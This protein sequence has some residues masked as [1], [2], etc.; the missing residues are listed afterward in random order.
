[1]WQQRAL[2]MH[3]EQTV[4]LIEIDIIRRKF[5]L[6]G[7]QGSFKELKCKTSEQFLNVLKV[8]RENEDQAEVRY[9]S[10]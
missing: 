8:I 9:L 3:D 4:L 10:K 1:M 2:K 7:D 5:M 6:H